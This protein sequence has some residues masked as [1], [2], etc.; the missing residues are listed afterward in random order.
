MA[1]AF[2]GIDAFEPWILEKLDSDP[3]T[4][5]YDIRRLADGLHRMIL[6]R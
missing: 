3:I 2:K 6:A 1:G 4:Q 5:Q